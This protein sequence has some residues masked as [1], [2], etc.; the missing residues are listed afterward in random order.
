MTRLASVKGFE[1][2][3]AK[4]LE[5]LSKLGEAGQDGAGYLCFFDWE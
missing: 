2:G 5:S 1:S 3:L 4:R